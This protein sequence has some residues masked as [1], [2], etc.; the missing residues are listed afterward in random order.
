MSLLGSLLGKGKT[1]APSTP[2][3]P[4]TLPAPTQPVFVIGDIHGR[5]D[6][7]ERILELVD[8]EIGQGKLKNP[9]LVFVGNLIDHGPSSAQVLSRMRELTDEFPENVFCL[10]GNHEQMCLDF[11]EAPVARHAR[12][13]KDGAAATFASFG[14]ALPEGGLD[15][16]TAENAALQL[17]HAIG[18]DMLAWMHRRP[19][20]LSSG[21]LHVVHAAAD[22][23][24]D[25]DD[26][27]PRVL[28][29]GHPE[30]LGVARGD[31]Q[32]VAHGHTMFERPHLKDSRI[33]VDT[34]AWQTG[35]L[36]AAMILPDGQVG[37]VQAVV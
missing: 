33:S 29:W 36:S 28:T 13:L 18:D 3:A 7:L 35:V 12:W 32:W 34:G 14:V 2:K 4:A 31:G 19:L 15:G 22:P 9:R 6:L 25:M 5:I 8:H 21:T 16:S 24:R 37:F 27:T 17:R 20:I 30:F 26:Q 23:R 1:K 11:L 10:M